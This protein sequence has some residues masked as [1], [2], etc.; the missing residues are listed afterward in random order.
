MEDTDFKDNFSGW[1]GILW[2]IH[3]VE[4]KK[5]LPMSF[6][7]LFIGLNY[8]IL[9][10][11]KDTLIIN[12]PGGGAECISFLKFYGVTPSA[13]LSTIIIFKLMDIL[14]AEKLF[15]VV[16]IA[17]LSFFGFFAF[18]IYPNKELFQMNLQSIAVWQAAF[19]NLHWVIP[20]IGNWSFSLFYIVT[21]LWGAVVV[22]LVFWQF[23]NSITNV[24]QAKRFYSLFGLIG[25]SGLL[26]GGVLIVWAAMYAKSHLSLTDSFEMNL[27]ILITFVIASGIITLFIHRWISAHVAHDPNLCNQ[28]STSGLKKTKLSLTESVKQVF[29]NRYLFLI[30]ILVVCYGLSINLIEGIWKA[31]IKIAFP[32]MN[33]YNEFMGKFS[34]VFGIMAMVMTILGANIIRRV[35]WRTAALITPLVTIF[36]AAIFFTFILYNISNDPYTPILGTTM[37]M[38]A[39][40]VGLFQNSFSKSVKY[41]LFDVTRNIAYI[42]LSADLRL[43]GQAAVEIVGGRAG[44]SGSAILQSTLLAMVSGNVS[45]LSLT[46]ILGPL[47]VLTCFVWVV[48]TYLLNKEFTHLVHEQNES[49]DRV[50]SEVANMPLQS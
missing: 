1:R 49:V 36:T 25:N 9:K 44:K 3:R 30:A 18:F 41:S 17:F 12:M 42:P 38:V 19:P 22:S 32:D 15:H 2:P 6:L 11:L 37:V 47:V 50:S 35:Q 33:N 28:N 34:V 8:T 7:L 27:Q 43:K 26:F 46:Y 13:I 20:L 24:P 16:L 48:A 4:L 39:V 10:A 23:A 21:E 29:T 45:L 14:G 40:I 5:F 31:E